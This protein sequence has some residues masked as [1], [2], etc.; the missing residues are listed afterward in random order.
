MGDCQ[1]KFPVCLDHGPFCVQ[2]AKQVNLRRSQARLE[3]LRTGQE[4]PP[5]LRSECVYVLAFQRMSI[6]CW[7]ND[8]GVHGQ[9][10]LLC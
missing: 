6:W 1:V 10:V 3:S 5:L 8:V 9:T 7:L 4:L 2:I